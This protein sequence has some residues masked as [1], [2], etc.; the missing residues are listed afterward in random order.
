MTAA[1]CRTCGFTD[2]PG[3]VTGDCPRWPAREDPPGMFAD[4]I[5]PEIV[6]LHAKLAHAGLQL[7]EEAGRLAN[8]TE[9]VLAA[10]GLPPLA[11]LMW[12]VAAAE[13]FRLA[14]EL[15][16]THGAPA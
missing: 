2:C 1:I 4:L 15:Y 12:H 16:V 10:Y 6:A 8:A 3:A 7:E 5:L 11:S 13:A 9:P 14:D